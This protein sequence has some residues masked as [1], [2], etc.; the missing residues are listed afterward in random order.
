MSDK[1]L[2]QSMVGLTVMIFGMTLAAIIGL[3]VK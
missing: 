2:K 1:A 3:I